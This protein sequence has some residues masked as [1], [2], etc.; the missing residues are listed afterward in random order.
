MRGT[1][2]ITAHVEDELSAMDRIT[3]LRGESI[4]NEVL[5]LKAKGA[6]I[7]TYSTYDVKSILYIGLFQ[8]TNT[9]LKRLQQ[10]VDYT[11]ERNALR[12]NSDLILLFNEVEQNSITIRYKHSPQF[13]IIEM[14]RDTMQT[15]NWTDRE[16]DQNMPVS[17]IARRAHYQ[18]S[19]QNLLKDRLLDNSYTP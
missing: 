4:H 11:V 9:A 12:F 2:N 3:A 18:L 1:V 7:F 15:Y 6:Q 19:A 5:F 16:I 17:A 13:H 8:G 10:N 14:K